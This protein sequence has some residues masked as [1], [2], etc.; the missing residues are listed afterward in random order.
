MH[1]DHIIISNDADQ[2]VI[3]HLY[4]QKIREIFQNSDVQICGGRIDEDPITHLNYP[5]LFV[6]ERF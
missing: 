5:D 3:H 4:I 1:P 6:Y 2:I